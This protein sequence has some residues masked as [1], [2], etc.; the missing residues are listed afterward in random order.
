MKRP[1]FDPVAVVIAIV[2]VLCVAFCSD[3]DQYRHPP[4][5]IPH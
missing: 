4:A 5:Y 3:T 2:L 1:F